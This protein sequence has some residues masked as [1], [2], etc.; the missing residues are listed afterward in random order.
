MSSAAQEEFNQ[1]LQNNRERNSTH[2]EDR[3]RDSN[4]SSGNEA[5]EEDNDH[6]ASDPSDSEDM[7]SR[8]ATYQ[9]PSTVYDAN[10]GPKGVIADAQAFERA[11][12]Q[13]FRKT[14]GGSTVGHAHSSSK[15]ISDDANLLSNNNNKPSSGNNTSDEDESRFMRKWRESRMHQLQS[16]S[17]RRAS[18]RRKVYGSVDAVDAAGYLDAIEKVASDTVVVVCIYDPDVS[19]P[20]L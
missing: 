17:M 16:F 5:E 6:L 14:L 7:R 2:P 12:K 9:V 18:P 15:S 13:S 1:I 11:R 3:D 4:S 19:I 10:T 8:T 20:H